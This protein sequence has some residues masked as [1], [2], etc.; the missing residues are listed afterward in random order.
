MLVDNGVL[1]DQLYFFGSDILEK[2]NLEYS[3]DVNVGGDGDGE[4]IINKLAEGITVGFDDITFFDQPAIIS[5]PELGLQKLWTN[6]DGQVSA[7][8][9]KHFITEIDYDRM[10]IILHKPE[11]FKPG[12]DFTDMKMTLVGS[13]SFSIPL[14]LK[15]SKDKTYEK[16]FILDLGGSSE[17]AF[18]YTKDDNL[19]PE[20][21]DSLKV[22][23]AGVQGTVKGYKK[24]IKEVDLGSL[25]LSKPVVEFVKVTEQNQH[26]NSKI[27]FETLKLFNTILDYHNSVL[28][29]K[30]NKMYKERMNCP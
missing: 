28:Y 6:T 25:K 5:P 22:L 3:G 26:M 13:G 19:E 1:W 8:F 27:G 20:Q 16:D 24:K 2:L 17:F 30:P 4:R 14:T 15:V 23:G 11:N 7:M 9:F 18:Y 29:L 21:N 12:K 10:V